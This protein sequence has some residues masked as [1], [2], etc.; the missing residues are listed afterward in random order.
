[1]KELLDE[2][3]LQIIQLLQNDGRMVS[4]EIAKTILRPSLFDM[5]RFCGSLFNFSKLA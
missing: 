2:V 1:M 3:D 4:S 5:L